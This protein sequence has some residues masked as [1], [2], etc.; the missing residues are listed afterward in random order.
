MTVC[1]AALY[2]NCKGVVLISDRMVTAQ[3]PIGYEFEHQENIKIIPV[4]QCDKVYVM[5]AGDVICGNEIVNLA[6]Q[7]IAG[8]EGQIPA[9][10]AATIIRESY[11]EIRLDKIVQRELEPRGMTL[12]D[13][14]SK[15]QQLS[16][17]VVQMVDQAMHNGNLEVEMLVA[18]QSGDTYTIHTIG[19]PGVIREDSSIGYSAIGIGAPHAVYSLIENSYFSTISKKKAI[20]LVKQAKQRSEAAPGVGKETTIVN[21]PSESQN[22]KN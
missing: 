13:Y 2:E 3:F 17:Q 9:S 15:Q 20:E 5:I 7:K 16:P 10:E 6:K 22:E 11:Q 18:G 12:D 19:N 1:I 21:I 4:D 8:N 14:Y